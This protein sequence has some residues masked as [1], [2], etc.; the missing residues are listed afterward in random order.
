MTHDPRI[1]L[2]IVVQDTVRELKAW[3]VLAG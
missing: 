1:M 3:C 2:E